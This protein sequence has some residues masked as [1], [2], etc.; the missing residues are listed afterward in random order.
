MRSREHTLKVVWIPA[1]SKYKFYTM[2]IVYKEYLA[3][4]INHDDGILDVNI[5]KRIKI[6]KVKL[7]SV[8]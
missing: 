2:G 4:I 8:I 1:Y 7:N 5:G 3:F 6:I